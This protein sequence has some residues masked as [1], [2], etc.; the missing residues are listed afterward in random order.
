MA[1]EALVPVYD[2]YIAEFS[3]Y[4]FQ[5]F[6]P[7]RLADDVLDQPIE[8]EGPAARQKPRFR[9][10]IR[11]EITS[12]KTAYQEQFR[13]LAERLP[14]DGSG[15]GWHEDYLE[16]DPFYGDVDDP[17][18]EELREAIVADADDIVEALRPL[19][20]VDDVWG[21]VEEMPP[22]EATARLIRWF[23]RPD[24]LWD[25]VEHVR[26]TLDVSAVAFLPMDEIDYSREALRLL[27]EGRDYLEQVIE[28]D[29][30]AA[31]GDD[32]PLTGPA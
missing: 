10:V 2:E 4:A 5:A 21:A 32:E 20:G 11:N 12:F 3:R 23:D 26:L 15:T 25:H 1:D 27:D 6:S 24:V 7:L 14:A 29:V 28:A 22:E 19:A 8:T 31:S 13:V 18:R 16:H 9:G 30:A 17:H